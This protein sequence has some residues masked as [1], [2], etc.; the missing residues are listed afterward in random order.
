MANCEP[1]KHHHFLRRSSEEVK[2]LRRFFGACAL[3]QAVAPASEFGDGGCCDHALFLQ[4]RSLFGD[5][6]V[7][8]AKACKA[9]VCGPEDMLSDAVVQVYDIAQAQLSRAAQGS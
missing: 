2:L 3:C 7:V 4:V 6:P 8:I 5:E 1:R 9:E